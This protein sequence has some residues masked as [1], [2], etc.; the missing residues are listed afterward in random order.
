MD[1]SV[2]D[3]LPPAVPLKTYQ[4]EDLKRDKER[5]K[6][7]Y[8]YLTKNLLVEQD[9]ITMEEKKPLVST[10]TEQKKLEDGEQKKT[11]VMQRRKEDIYAATNEET[12]HSENKEEQ[13][14]YA[15]NERLIM[16]QENI[17]IKYE[18]LVE[19]DSF[20]KTD[21]KNTESENTYRASKI[22]Q[23][24]DKEQ[25]AK[26]ILDTSRL[27]AGAS[28]SNAGFVHDSNLD[29]IAS[30][31][32]TLE[33][34]QE[35]KRKHS[36]SSVGT[37]T[38]LSLFEAI[39]KFKPLTF[40]MPQFKKFALHKKGSKRLKHDFKEQKYTVIE[41]VKP[42]V[43][44]QTQPNES[45]VY[46]YIPLNPTAE[47]LEK[48]R[49]EAMKSELHR[50][51]ALD[52]R[53]D[54]RKNSKATNGTM[55]SATTS[56][57]IDVQSAS[58]K[59]KGLQSKTD[60]TS[61]PVKKKSTN[62]KGES[63][64]SVSTKPDASPV[65]YI[66]IPLKPPENETWN[67]PSPKK[68]FDKIEAVNTKLISTQVTKVD[69]PVV[70]EEDI[71]TETKEP[72]KSET[73]IK[74]LSNINS[75]PDEQ[76]SKGA[77]KKK[78]G[79]TTKLTKDI[80]KFVSKLKGEQTKAKRSSSSLKV[81]SKQTSVENKTSPT[82]KKHDDSPVEY[83]Y[84][85]LKGPLPDE[86]PKQVEVKRKENI[87]TE[88]KI[89]E[90]TVAIVEKEK[91][92][93]MSKFNG[94]KIE[95]KSPPAIKKNIKQFTG[96]KGSPKSSM[97]ETVEK[98]SSP[99]LPSV[100]R[101]DSPVEYIYI[102]LKPLDTEVSDDKAEGTRME[103]QT[104]KEDSK[105]ENR[106]VASIKQ[107]ESK[108]TKLEK[109]PDKP[110]E[111]QKENIMTKLKD[112]KPKKTQVLKTDVK[113]KKEQ[114][115]EK[116]KSLPKDLQSNDAPVEYIY[117]PLKPPTSSEKAESNTEATINNEESMKIETVSDIV[118]QSSSLP[119]EEPKRRKME[120][121]TEEARLI[122]EAVIKAWQGFKTKPLQKPMPLKR[123]DP[124]TT[125]PITE[126][127]SGS[128]VF[129]SGESPVEYIYIPLNPTEEQLEYERVM[130]EQKRLPAPR[131]S[132]A[133]RT[134]DRSV[135]AE[136]KSKRAAVKTGAIKKQPTEKGNKVKDST[137]KL[138]E[139]I[140][141]FASKLKDM[142][143]KSKK[144]TY[145][146][147]KHGS[148]SSRMSPTTSKKPVDSRSPRISRQCEDTPVEYIFIPLKD[149]ET[150]EEIE[151]EAAISI[152]SEIVE[153]V[154]EAVKKS[155]TLEES[156]YKLLTK[157]DEEDGLKTAI[158]ASLNKKKPSDEVL[159]T[160]TSLELN[161]KLPIESIKMEM[162]NDFDKSQ[163][164]DENTVYEKTI[165]MKDEEPDTNVSTARKLITVDEQ[166]IKDTSLEDEHN[167]WSKST[168]LAV[169]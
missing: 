65:E 92:S 25:I 110:K 166:I 28:A 158:I 48:E 26:S 41:E 13:M 157:E 19:D 101:S 169:C 149:P 152:P 17:E 150:T 109:I 115:S 23:Y 56:R 8:T 21:S 127:I 31:S 62:A 50:R 146:T 46:I 7:P 111:T 113:S 106:K 6:Y 29:V 12:E 82:S 91:P 121:N 141:K 9:K 90:V 144:P 84:I 143:K 145:K 49:Q 35:H 153:K 1:F 72:Q 60:K 27:E 57:N 87:S 80:K 30:V 97:K 131:A 36:G 95:L 100:K 104:S 162:K 108:V 67:K 47:D 3:A 43:T 133:A 34:P 32:E 16:R 103:L 116:I 37:K 102:P 122:M 112:L 164:G 136:D 52:F 114:V 142:K 14:I 64:K 39:K 160:Q 81:A 44:L 54:R 59:W 161:R 96:K 148:K 134:P 155:S 105:L 88:V 126:K 89:Q 68:A 107:V 24:L 79:K 2:K 163:N 124:K 55:S 53:T 33:V 98:K 86:N 18:L 51:L 11:K 76:Q 78:S 132:S 139:D 22:E 85:P 42:E 15:K 147:F 73:E 120:D 4:W 20:Y 45:P 75:K 93:L 118:A 128:V 38:N 117:I 66:Y 135:V 140:K 119:L 74:Q 5:G 137:T 123:T 61:P 151:I 83:I 99:L 168:L 69:K 40:A 138:T 71:I 129:G 154:E 165:Q 10:D 156:H 58:F 130:K 77:S 125:S 63:L 159:E 94:P 167:K 70:K